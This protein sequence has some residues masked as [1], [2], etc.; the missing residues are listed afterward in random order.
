MGEVGVIV[1][2]LSLICSPCLSLLPLLGVETLNLLH[3]GRRWKGLKRK[4]QEKKIGTEWFK[5]YC[6]FSV[7]TPTIY[8]GLAVHLGSHRI[9]FDWV[10]LVIEDILDTHKKF[11]FGFDFQNVTRL[12]YTYTQHVNSPDPLSIMPLPLASI[13]GP[14]K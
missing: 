9:W 11:R 8:L 13:Y 2:A 4:G 5:S 7:L 6:S 14:H 1:N 3:L 10:I 12:W